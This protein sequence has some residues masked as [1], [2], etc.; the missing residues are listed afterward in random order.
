MHSS[1]RTLGCRLPNEEAALV[2]T[3][4]AASGEFVS[5]VIRRAVL[6]EVREAMALGA[7]RQMET[8]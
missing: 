6:R 4:A 3:Y 8:A 2:E 7:A 5:H 1:H